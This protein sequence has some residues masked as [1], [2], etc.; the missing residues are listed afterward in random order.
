MYFKIGRL[1]VA[2][3]RLKDKKKGG[4][5]DDVE[6]SNQL[7]AMAKETQLFGCY[8]HIKGL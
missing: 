4:L 2:K 5:L 3:A 6:K 1:R 8:H 7:K